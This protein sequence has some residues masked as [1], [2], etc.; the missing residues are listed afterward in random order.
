M[1]LL[2]GNMLKPVNYH[3]AICSSG[4]EALDRTA[5][6]LLNISVQRIKR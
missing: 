4:G 1:L 3:N 5:L 2:P 6:S